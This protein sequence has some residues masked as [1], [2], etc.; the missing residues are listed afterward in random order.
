[1]KECLDYILLL[2]MDLYFEEVA[3]VD[4]ELVDQH[5]LVIEY[6][7]NVHQEYLEVSKQTKNRSIF[8]IQLN[9]QLLE[10]NCLRKVMRHL[11]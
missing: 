4:Y 1:M 10:E 7:R 11:L 6:D 2:K 8:L 3:Q 9:F 5:R